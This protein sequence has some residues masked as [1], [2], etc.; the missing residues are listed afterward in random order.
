[1]EKIRNRAK[2]GNFRGILKGKIEYRAKREEIF[3]K[4]K[5]PREAREI[6]GINKKPREAREILELIRNRA[7]C[8]I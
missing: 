1:M 5:K 2:R 3:G 4:N 7:K 8:G 6:F